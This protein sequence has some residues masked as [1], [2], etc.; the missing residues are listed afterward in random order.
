M[1][2]DIALRTARRLDE[3]ISFDRI[4]PLDPAD[5][6]HNRFARLPRNRNSQLLAHCP[7]TPPIIKKILT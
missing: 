2:Q 3:P 6:F 5:D 4:E 1:Q 7:T